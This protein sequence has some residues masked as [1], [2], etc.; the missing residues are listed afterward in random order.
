MKLKS[1]AAAA[2]ALSVAAV[3]TGAATYG[4]FKKTVVRSDKKKAFDLDMGTSWEQYMPFILEKREWIRTCGYKEH[5][6]ES[7]DGLKL[8]AKY[9]KSD[10]PTHKTIIAVHGYK[11]CGTYEFAA[12]ASMYH[13]HGY[14]VLLL[15]DRA[16][17]DSEGK[18]IGFGTLD[19]Y[20]VRSWTEYVCEKIDPKAK[21]YLHGISMGGSSVL[22]SGGLGLCENVLGII[23][24]CAFTSAWEVMVSIFQKKSAV[25]VKPILKAA[26]AVCKK[27]A[28]YA[29]DE[30]STLDA[31]QNITV[32]VLFIHGAADIFVPPEMSQRN[33]DACVSKKRLVFFE[34]AGHAESFYAA[35]EMYEK[36][37]LGFIN[38]IN[39]N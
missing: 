39:N 1:I 26:S 37:V 23:A 13:D 22:M 31:V 36:T 20:D 11:S 3:G 30:A 14:N 28:G 27:T 2:A 8:R 17:G 16:H 25:P 9:I 33:Y 4:M 38:E 19:R 6:I 7:F 24:D 29:F 12:I 34:N 15:D 10:I 21:I 32:P 18:Y 35:P 5:T